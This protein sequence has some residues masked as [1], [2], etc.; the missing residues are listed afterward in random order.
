MDSTNTQNNVEYVRNSSHA[1]SVTSHQLKLGFLGNFSIFLERLF[2]CLL[3]MGGV[4]KSVN[5]D[6]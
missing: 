4:L 3:I 2:F 1:T 5:S 6:L